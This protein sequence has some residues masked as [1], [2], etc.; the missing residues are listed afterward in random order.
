V[1]LDPTKRDCRRSLSRLFNLAFTD[2]IPASKA[3]KLAYIVGIILK[4]LE[5][6]ELRWQQTGSEL[7]P[8][9]QEIAGKI[10]ECMRMADAQ[11]PPPPAGREGEGQGDG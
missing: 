2:K 5:T 10:R 9:P 11:V 8:S 6:D 7:Q 3:A 4:S 1:K